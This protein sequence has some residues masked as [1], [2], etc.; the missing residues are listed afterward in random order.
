MKFWSLVGLLVAV[1]AFAAA[2]FIAGRDYVAGAT[3]AGLA[4]VVATFVLSPPTGMSLL[5][6]IL[7]LAAAALAYVLY[8]VD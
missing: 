3:P 1:L 7:L 6:V 2:Y 4:A 8:E 5:A